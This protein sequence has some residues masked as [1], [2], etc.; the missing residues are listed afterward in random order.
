[1]AKLN[2]NAA[3]KEPMTEFKNLP[4]G[5]YIASIIKSEIKPTAKK[6]GKRLNLTFKVLNG[7]HKGS[8]LFVG[9]NIENPSQQAVEIS[10]REL[11]SICDAI[12][13]GKE[14]ISDSEELHG[15]PMEITVDIEPPSGE[16]TDEK[17]GETKFRYKAKNVI[18]GYAP[19]EG[20]EVLNESESVPTQAG[21]DKL[22]WK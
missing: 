10:D 8:Q 15:L 4:E 13:K 12:G 21:G 17:T 22:P 6:D 14:N 18:T 11:K 19:Y 2:F 5:K 9:L 1:M 20:S 16:Y 7:E 3:D